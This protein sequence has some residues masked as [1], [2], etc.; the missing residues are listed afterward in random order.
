MYLCTLNTVTIAITLQILELYAA[1]V[2]KLITL[3]RFV[4]VAKF[5]RH[6]FLQRLY[7]V[8]I[9]L[10]QAA[11][12]DK[13]L[14]ARVFQAKAYDVPAATMRLATA[15]GAS[16]QYLLG[17]AFMQERLLWLWLVIQLDC[18]LGHLQNNHFC[19]GLIWLGLDKP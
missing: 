13:R 5:W 14:Q 3:A 1:T 10:W 4:K 16:K 19:Y 6:F 12:E 7:M 8:A 2:I 17:L 9:K 18:F 15:C 11:P